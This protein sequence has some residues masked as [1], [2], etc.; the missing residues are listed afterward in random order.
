MT[1]KRIADIEEALGLCLDAIGLRNLVNELLAEVKRLRSTAFAGRALA[2]HDEL[3][4]S[5]EAVKRIAKEAHGNWDRAEDHR[6]GKILWA[7]AGGMPKYRADIDAIH[8]A[9]DK[10][11]KTATADNA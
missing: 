11:T 4:T 9:I 3:V 1:D 8:A 2:C 7:L 6:V 5:L 10:A